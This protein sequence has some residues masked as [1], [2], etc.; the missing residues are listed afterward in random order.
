MSLRSESAPP[1]ATL[2]DAFAR[3]PSPMVITD[4]RAPDNPIAWANDAFLQVTGYTADEIVGR[5]CRMLQG[6][7]TDRFTVERIRSAVQA[8]EPISVELLNYRK[9]GTTFWN[10][11]TI[12]P[13]NDAEGLAFFYAAQADMTYVHQ[14]EVSMR[15]T[16]D[17]LER[18]VNA[19]TQDLTTALEQKTALLHEVDHRVKNNL[20]VI[21]SL[22]L[23]K[24]RRTPEGEARDALQGMAERIGALST[25]HRMLYSE[26]D[27]THFNLGDF[28]AEFLA[29]MNAGLDPERRRVEADVESI[30]VAAAMAAPLALMIHELTANA[31]RHAFPGEREGR[32]SIVARRTERGMHMTIRDDGVGVAAA[33]PNPAGFGRN[34]VEMVV[35]QMRGTIAWADAGPGTTVDIDIPLQQPA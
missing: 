26:G 20:Q 8:A 15:G 25:A 21:S 34:L 22:M 13:V 5:N 10:A 7:A 35:R 31:L 12:T 6:P 28:A 16:N 30:A 9:D 33:A 17:E 4:A 18:L 14:M 27:C 1:L 23:L 3:S 19:R 29:D 24:A 11:M 32:V 2:V